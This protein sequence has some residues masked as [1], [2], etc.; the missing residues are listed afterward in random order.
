LNFRLFAAAPFLEVLARVYDLAPVA[1]LDPAA[2]GWLPFFASNKPFRRRPVFAL[3]FGYHFAAADIHERWQAGQWDLVRR[4]SREHARN[5]RLTTVGEAGLGEGVQV[6]HNPVLRL[7]GAGE[8]E[9]LY[10]RNLR[11]NLKKEVNKC[12]RLGVQLEFTQAEQDLRS[13]Y[14]VLATQYVREHRMVFQPLPLLRQL[15]RPGTGGRLLVARDASR[16][17]I[18][19]MFMLED[20]EVL[21]YN[22]GARSR[23]ANLSV[24]TVLIDHAIRHAKAAGCSH[25]DFGSTALSDQDLLDFK[26]RWGC[27]NLPVMAYHTLHAPAPIDLA[28][29]H[30]G[31]RRWFA[32]LPVPVAETL[33]PRL[34][35]WLI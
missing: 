16:R 25:F 18:G 24:G 3:P 35:P 4:F 21:H 5:V 12:A 14:R 10:S 30:P 22:W 26:L 9:A 28:S 29:S 33:M 2:P 19:G 6:A 8:I 13:F 7:R 20:G 11:S 32:R 23:L 1:V 27:E 31:A 15:M 34:V 17:V